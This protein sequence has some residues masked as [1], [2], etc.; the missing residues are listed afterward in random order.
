MSDLNERQP[1]LKATSPTRSERTQDEECIDT[2]T[3]QEEEVVQKKT[4]VWAVLWKVVL[5][6]VVIVLLAAFIKG[7]IDADDVD[8]RKLFHV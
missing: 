4:S 2:A 3:S 6:I 1:L 8:V 5:G 7:F